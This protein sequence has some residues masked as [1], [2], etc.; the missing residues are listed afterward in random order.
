M[1]PRGWNSA[2]DQV[3]LALDLRPDL[4]HHVLRAPLT[5]DQERVHLGAER[6][7]HLAEGPMARTESLP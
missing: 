1:D 7:L 6:L 3:D 5:I 4:I 2:A